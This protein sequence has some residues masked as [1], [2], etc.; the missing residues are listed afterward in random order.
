MV[1]A[2]LGCDW[3]YISYSDQQEQ[4]LYLCCPEGAAVIWML[5]II[6]LSFSQMNWKIEGGERKKELQWKNLSGPWEEAQNW[7]PLLI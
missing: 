5:Q 1:L 3:W 2:Q 7:K 4:G 6:Y